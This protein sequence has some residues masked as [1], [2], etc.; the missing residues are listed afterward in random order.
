MR[1]TK[2]TTRTGDDGYTL[3]AG[4]RIP[5]SSPII[6]AIGKIDSLNAQIGRLE[7]EGADPDLTRI[8]QELFNIGAELYLGV[9][10]Y[11]KQEALDHLEAIEFDLPP[12]T[13]F[14][15]PQGNIAVCLAHLCRTAAREAECA[16]VEA[17]QTGFVV[18]PLAL[19]YIN[20]LSDFFFNFARQES[21]DIETL[22]DSER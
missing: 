19:Q 15:L 16:M 22:W 4:K 17:S 14:I 5:K 20:R 21:T 10:K 11:F 6:V 18:S 7:C 12:L 13:E 1:I 9:Q 8:Q 3:Y 2:V